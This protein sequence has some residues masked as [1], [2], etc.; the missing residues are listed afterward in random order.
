PGQTKS[1]LRYVVAGRAE[2]T[3][4]AGQQVAAVKAG[5]TALTTTPDLAG[6]SPALGCTIAN[7]APLFDP[8]TCARNP[9]P[10]ITPEQ[11]PNLPTTTSGYDVFNKSTTQLE[12]DMRSGLTTSQEI[13]RAYLDR[14]AAYDSGPFGFHAFITVSD[15]AMAQ[16]KAADERRAAG[17]TSE[18]LGIP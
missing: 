18:L 3:A 4:T 1:L 5:A 2:T 12:A 7:F 13:T 10:A 11:P 17:D 16:A 15:T 9:A 6:I 8:A 14:I